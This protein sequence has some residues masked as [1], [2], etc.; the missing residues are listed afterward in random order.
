MK[1]NY[2]AYKECAY[3]ARVYIKKISCLLA[4]NISILYPVNVNV[5][6]ILFQI[7]QEIRD[8]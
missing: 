6:V 8:I 2:F 5:E 4:K 1:C 3:D 7:L